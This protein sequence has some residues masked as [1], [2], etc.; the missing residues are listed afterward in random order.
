MCITHSL[1]QPTHHT[2]TQET[3]WKLCFNDTHTYETLTHTL[4]H[5]HTH[6]PHTM[7]LEN[8]FEID[9]TALVCKDAKLVG[10]ITIGAG[11]VIHAGASINALAGP[12]II[13]MN[14]IIEEKSR[15][16]NNPHSSV[17]SGTVVIIGDH[18]LISMGAVVE[19]AVIG[20]CNVIGTNAHLEPGSELPDGCIIGTN[21]V[22]AKGE[23][24]AQGTI[25]YGPNFVRRVDPKRQG[26]NR[27]ELL[28]KHAALMSQ[29]KG[30]PII[31]ST[32]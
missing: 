29:L 21:I 14:N 28:R 4:T 25:V 12:V 7:S 15:I 32:S 30:V 10:N 2:Y 13:G 16:V 27:A 18:N 5:T 24:L 26:S 17:G 9:P 6:T 1:T 11:T 31:E 3:V 8:K 23:D 19:A 20:K 22:L